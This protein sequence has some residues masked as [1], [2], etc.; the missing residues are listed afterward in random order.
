MK[1]SALICRLALGAAAVATPALAQ[2]EQWLEYHTSRE[3]RS[4]QYVQLTTNPPPNI[5][6]PQFSSQPWFARWATPMDPKGGRWIALDRSKKTGL[7]DRVYIDSNGNGRLDDETPATPGR[8]DQYSAY[9]DGIKVVF[10]GEDGPISY[11]LIY[12][13]SQYEGNSNPQLLMSSGCFYGGTVELGGKKRHLELIDG[14]VNGTFNDLNPDAYGSDRI[15]IDGDKQG[16]RYLGKMIE[17]DGQ[18][19][20]IEAA[21]D[22]AFVKLQKAEGLT[23]GTVRVPETISK[24]VAYGENGHFERK[25]AKGE[26]TLPA[27]KYRILEWTINRK[28]SKGASWELMGYNFPDSSRFT[29]AEAKPAS[30]QLGEPIRATLEANETGSQVRFNLSFK[31]QGGESI[32]I[33]KG[34]QRPPG[35]KLWLAGADGTFRATNTFE[36]G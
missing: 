14:N 30:L 36:F 9:F 19:Y 8:S 24:F 3:A 35:P 4:Y 29:A 22:G 15:S 18:C 33:E 20:R 25:P 7:Y 31:G 12:R 27:G 28:D 1:L 23:F 6:L 34:N 32:Q 10:K 2:K 5:S 11:H 21:R 17:V 16:E 26:L 13:F